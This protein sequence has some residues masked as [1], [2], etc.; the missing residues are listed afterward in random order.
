[1]Q[2]QLCSSSSPCGVTV[3]ATSVVALRASAEAIFRSLPCSKIVDEV[4]ARLP[5]IAIEP[6]KSSRDGSIAR[7]AS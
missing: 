1:V 3:S 5:V 7:R 6:A 2:L 4:A